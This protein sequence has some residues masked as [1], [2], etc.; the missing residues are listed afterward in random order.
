M[1]KARDRLVP[2][3]QN[4]IFCFAQSVS[5]LPHLFQFV[6]RLSQGGCAGE[7]LFF[8]KHEDTIGDDYDSS[9]Y[10]CNENKSDD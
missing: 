5:S 6:I 2:L 1:L 3:E 10:S 4:A 8:Q 7:Q 9:R